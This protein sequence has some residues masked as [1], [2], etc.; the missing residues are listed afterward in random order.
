MLRD[1][2]VGLIKPIENSAGLFLVPALL[3]SSNKEKSL[4]DNRPP[5]LKIPAP[6]GAESTLAE[7]RLLSISR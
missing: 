7:K 2:L 4:S 6:L 1:S 3:A 5:A